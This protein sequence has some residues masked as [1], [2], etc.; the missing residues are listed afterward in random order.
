VE[1]S[2]LAKSIAARVCF[3]R[4]FFTSEIGGSTGKSSGIVAPRA[5][6]VCRTSLATCL[7][8]AIAAASPLT[9]VFVMTSAAS[10]I[11]KSLAESSSVPARSRRFS[12]WL[13]PF[14]S[15]TSRNGLSYRPSYLALWNSAWRS[16][17]TSLATPLIFRKDLLTFSRSS[18]R[19]ESC[20]F[21]SLQFHSP[22]LNDEIG[23]CSGDFWLARIAVHRDE[24]TRCTAEIMIFGVLPGVT[25]LMRRHNVLRDLLAV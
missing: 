21:W 9:P 22:G 4:R 13:I 3:L 15:F 17:P 23:L 20:A 16:T 5:F 6:I 25:Y 12:F 18:S 14:F 1:R 7:F 2:A 11:W 10:S 19:R 24:G 8:I